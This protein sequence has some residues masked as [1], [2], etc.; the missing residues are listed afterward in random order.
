[1]NWITIVWSMNAAGC[2]TLAGMYLL[3]WCKQRESSVYLVVSCNA[4]AGAALTAFELALLRARRFPCGGSSK[5]LFALASI[6]DISERKLAELEAARQRNELV[7]LSRVTTLGEFSSSLAHELSLPLAAILSNAQ[8]AQRFLAHGGTDLAEVREILN[9][10]VSEDKRAGEVIRRLRLLLK[11]GEVRQH[12]LGI[13]EVVQD[14]LKLMRGDLV[15]QNVTVD[16][17][18]AQNLPTVTGDPVQ[19]Q[20]VLLN[21]VVNACDAM[22]DCDTPERRLLVRTGM[23]NGSSAVRVSVTDRGDSIPEEK[24]EQIF[25]PFF[26]TKAK[27][28]GLGLSVCRTIIVAHQGKLWATNNADCG[29]TFH[30]SLP[31]GGQARR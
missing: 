17:E 1:M 23:E 21:L 13:N 18:L 26:T 5:G 8:A 25:E 27:G 10:I 11:K 31:T 4:V 15:N 29:A 24:M 19:L 22:T 20:Q 3:V 7:H 9:D 14:V 12:S 2:L 16:I 28:M 30:F 6:V